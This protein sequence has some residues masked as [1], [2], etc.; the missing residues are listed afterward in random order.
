MGEAGEARGAVERALSSDS[1][2]GKLTSLVPNLAVNALLWLVL[3]GA[4]LDFG[5]EL[6]YLVVNMMDFISL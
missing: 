3:V 6:E 2:K 1:S 4:L 5:E